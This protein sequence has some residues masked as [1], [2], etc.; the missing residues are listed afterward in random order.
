MDKHNACVSHVTINS[1]LPSG[2][3]TLLSCYGP[4]VLV[5]G[6]NS[7]AFLRFFIVSIALLT[8]AI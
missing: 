3:N 8:K 7:Y 5:T 2:K 6:A 1:M 4:E